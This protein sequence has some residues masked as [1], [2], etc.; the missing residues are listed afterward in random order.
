V[1]GSD[2]DTDFGIPP[3]LNEYSY[4][5]PLSFYDFSPAAPVLSSKALIKGY[6]GGFDYFMNPP[7]SHGFPTEQQGNQPS[8]NSAPADQKRSVTGINEDNAI[9]DAE[10]AKLWSAFAE[11][12]SGGNVYMKEFLLKDFALERYYRAGYELSAETRDRAAKAA[13]KVASTLPVVAAAA[14]AVSALSNAPVVSALNSAPVPAVSTLSNVP[15]VSINAPN[16][17]TLPPQVGLGSLLSTGLISTMFPSKSWSQPMAGHGTRPF[18]GTSLFVNL[19]LRL[20]TLFRV[21]DSMFGLLFSFVSPPWLYVWL[22]AYL[23]NESSRA[24]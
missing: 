12:N 2:F 1:H 5:W 11:K 10:W 21:I 6:P 24:K 7:P 22:A 23:L 20:R 9:S 17:V 3:T 14:P 16:A 15:S 18:P 19:Q 4:N 13:A 8:V